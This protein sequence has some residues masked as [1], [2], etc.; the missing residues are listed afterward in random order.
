MDADALAHSP[1]IIWASVIL[2]VAVLVATTVPK[3]LGPLGTG[4]AEW[5]ARR[6]QQRID[7]D[8]ADLAEAAR[9]ITGL[10]GQLAQE[11][12]D[13]DDTRARFADAR[14]A[15]A[16]REKRWQEEAKRMRVWAF[17]IVQRFT[18]IDPPIEDVP[19]IMTPD[20]ISKEETP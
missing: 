10:R 1:V 4:L 14:R 11:R 12:A 2:G 7:G 6:R 9:T 19:L 8:D 18:G 17:G 20:P 5:A 3:I 13:H 15:W 16:E